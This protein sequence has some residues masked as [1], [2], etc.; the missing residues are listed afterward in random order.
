M[1]LTQSRYL[2]KRGMFRWLCICMSR[3]VFFL[4]LFRTLILVLWWD[5]QMARHVVSR[6]VL[7]PG[8]NTFQT[9]TCTCTNA[10]QHQIPPLASSS[11]WICIHQLPY[12]PTPRRAPGWLRNCLVLTKT[13]RMNHMRAKRTINWWGLHSYPGILVHWFNDKFSLPVV[14]SRYAL[15]GLRWRCCWLGQAT[16]HARIPQ[17]RTRL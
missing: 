9:C 16:Y 8:Q 5:L 17:W 12:Q 15:F 13:A 14:R 4:Y 11:A 6:Q 1:G 10:H 3:W 2:N 7:Y